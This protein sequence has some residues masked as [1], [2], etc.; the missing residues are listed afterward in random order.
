[1]NLLIALKLLSLSILSIFAIPGA[2]VFGSSDLGVFVT[3]STDNVKLDMKATETREVADFTVKPESVVQIRQGENL[4]VF[5]VPPDRVDKVKITDSA[6]VRNELVPLGNNQYSL[7]GV[8]AGVY[9]LDVIV[10]P[11]DS[12]ERAAHET[13]LII[14]KPG[15]P[16]QNIQNIIQTI[17]KVKV[18]TQIDIDF[19]DDSDECSS[20]IGSAGLRFPFNKKSECQYEEWRD[21]KDDA[22][23]GIK[24]D[25]RCKDINHGFEDD[26]E[27][28]ANKKECDE[29]WTNPKPL[30]YR[31]GLP[32]CHDPLYGA[33]KLGNECYDELDHDTCEDGFVDSGNGCEPEPVVEKDNFDENGQYI[34]K[35]GETVDTGIINE[36][37]IEVE[38]TDGTEES[39]EVE[40]EEEPETES[41]SDEPDSDEGTN[42]GVN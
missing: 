42:S 39:E 20:K 35:G 18:V 17:Q 7:V 2:T 1:M 11:P 16:V 32:L 19:D 33:G 29:H 26:C 37:P 3:S 31:N 24:W 4:N 5:T 13:I 12:S 28:F 8:N 41:N 9:V 25:D 10:N 34:P 40:E 15:E 30:P 22:Q 23:K 6:G 36:D 14:L 38:E 21:C 27:G